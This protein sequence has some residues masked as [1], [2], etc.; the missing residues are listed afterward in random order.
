M[1]R[2]ATHARRLAAFAVGARLADVEEDA[3]RELKLRVLDSLGC[4]FGALGSPVTARIRRHV[5]T[6][7]GSPATSL[8]G[9]GRS[10]PDRAA[11]LN[12]ALIRYLDFN[13]SYLAPGETCH[14]SDNV[15]PILAAA[16]YAGA[17][18]GDFL[19]ALAVAYEVQCRLS[20]VAPVRAH[21]FDHTTQGS[22]AVAAGA[23]ASNTRPVQ[24]SNSSA[25][26]GKP[27]GRGGS[28]T[29]PSSSRA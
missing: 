3:R 7:G 11:L 20:E 4:A 19:T 13:D 25:C 17:E 10:A 26:V 8:I 5:E 16:E 9:G 27:G 6:L 29:A 22:F 12:G 14:P 24:R 1:D 2:Q 28:S 15:A 21:G 23:T 18:G